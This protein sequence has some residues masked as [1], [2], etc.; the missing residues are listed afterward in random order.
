VGSTD[1]DSDGVIVG[2][3]DGSPTPANST[4]LS[5]ERLLRNDFDIGW[6]PKCLRNSSDVIYVNSFSPRTYLLSLLPL[7]VDTKSVFVA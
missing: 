7:L 4:L 5:A 6:I 3:V 2:S 1:G